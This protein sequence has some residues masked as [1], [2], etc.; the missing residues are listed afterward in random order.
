[1]SIHDYINKRKYLNK[2]I[3]KIKKMKH[4]DRKGF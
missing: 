3:I 1:M 4:N 2:P